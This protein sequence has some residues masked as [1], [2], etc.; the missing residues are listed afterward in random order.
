MNRETDLILIEQNL[1]EL[2][3]LSYQDLTEFT[4]QRPSTTRE[5][6]PDGEEYQTEVQVFWGGKK[7]GTFEYLLRPTAVR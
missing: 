2:R 4:P 7:G 6:G 5:K 3:K 1:K